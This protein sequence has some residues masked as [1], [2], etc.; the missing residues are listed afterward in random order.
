MFLDEDQTKEG[1]KRNG[2]ASAARRVSSKARSGQRPGSSSGDPR[3]MAAESLS[4][5]DGMHGSERTLGSQP[6]ES[7][8]HRLERI[9][10]LN[11]HR[12]ELLLLCARSRRLLESFLCRTWLVDGGRSIVPTFRSSQSTGKGVQRGGEGTEKHQMG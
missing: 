8:S 11:D 1:Q 9:E 7:L 3:M 12:D 2:E 10:L 4:T 5:T 6:V